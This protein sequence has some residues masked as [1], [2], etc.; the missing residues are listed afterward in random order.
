MFIS[1]GVLVDLF[2]RAAAHVAVALV[3][4]L[5]ESRTV[6]V[7][8]LYEEQLTD[9]AGRPYTVYSFLSGKL[10]GLR[11]GN[12]ATGNRQYRLVGDHLGST[13][14]LVD[15]SAPPQVAQRQY[16]SP[17]GEQALQAAG[18]TSLMSADFTGQRLDDGSGVAL[19]RR[20]VI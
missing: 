17:Y 1:R 20:A 3:R 13:T 16:Y 6:Y 14:L 4:S 2:N 11:R 19:L 18:N 10:V 9:A 7:G 12:R 8:S 15:T 5:G